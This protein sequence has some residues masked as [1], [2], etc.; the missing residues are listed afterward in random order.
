MLVRL[1]VL[2]S[3]DA[4]AAGRGARFGIETQSD[5]IGW[6]ILAAFGY[7]LAGLDRNVVILVGYGAIQMT[8]YEITLMVR[9]RLLVT[10]FLFDNKCYTID[11]ELHD[12][13]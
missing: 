4:L 10:I 9:H 12:G 11:V 3:G 5:H 7:A 2:R 8:L 1:I 13:P 6:S